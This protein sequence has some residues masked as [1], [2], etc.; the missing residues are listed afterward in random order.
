METRLEISRVAHRIIGIVF[1]LVCTL[2]FGCGKKD[3]T[4]ELSKKLCDAVSKGYL[5]EV[6]KLTREYPK[7][8][9]IPGSDE[10]SSTPLHLAVNKNRLEIART[11]LENGADINARNKHGQTPLI[12]AAM[13]GNVE[14]AQ[15]FL[16]RNARKDVRDHWGQSALM[17]AT[18]RRYPDVAKLVK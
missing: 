9:N 15:M 3:R 11:L 17:Y 13:N 12:L 1:L 7:L 10:M 5:V 18:K 4:A 8:V 14:F 16:S 6:Q 2:T